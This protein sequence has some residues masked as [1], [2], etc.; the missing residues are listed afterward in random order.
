[1]PRA[2]SGQ[3]HQSEERKDS[4]VTRLSVYG[5]FQRIEPELDALPVSVASG[6]TIGL[7]K[8][9]YDTSRPGRTASGKDLV[10]DAV[11]IGLAVGVIVL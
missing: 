3:V 5:L 6:A 8:E 11:G 7:L 2:R 1:M 10:A 4:L 9:L